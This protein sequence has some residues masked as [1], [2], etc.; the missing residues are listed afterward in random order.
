MLTK[1]WLFI[2]CMLLLAYSAKAQTMV[3]EFSAN[4]T[5]GCAPLTVNFRDLTTGNPKYWNWDFGNGTLA[6]VQFPTVVYSQPGTY[7][8]TLVVRNADGTNGITKTH[9]ITVHPSPTAD[10]FANITMGCTPVNIQFVDN[11]SS[12]SGNIVSWAWDFGDGTT[13]NEQN[14]Q[15]TYT[16]T[17]FYSVTLTV[18]SSTGCKSITT[19]GR[20]IRIVA[21]VKP[22]FDNSKITACEAPYNIKFNN[23]TSSPG[24]VTYQWNLDNGTN[25]TETSPTTTYATPGTYNVTLTATSD[26]GCTGTITKAVTLSG[27]TTSIK[28]P[29]EVC[30]NQT[31]FFV[32]ESSV[33]PKSTVWDFGNG[34]TK[35]GTDDSTVYTTPATYTVK[36][37]NT[38]E[39][40]T[41]SATKTITVRPSPSIDF[42]ATNAAACKP[43]LPVTFQD[44]SPAPIVKWFWEFGDGSTGT[45]QTTTHTYNAEG[46]YDV[47]VTFTDD[48]G[49]EGKITKQAV[50][51]ITKPTITITNAGAGGC[52]PYT[53]TPTI[54]VNAV[55]GVATYVW[56]WADG[57]T[58]TTSGSD[59]IPSHIYTNT[60]TYPVKVTITTNSGCT[61][62]AVM[63]DPV[64]TGTKPAP[65]FSISATDVCASATITFNDLTPPPVDEW[66]WN[67]GDGTTS[68]DRNPT[69]QFL[70]TGNFIV[71]LTAFNNRCA[72]TSTGQTVHI[73]GPI[74]RFIYTVDCNNPTSVT[75]TDQSV[76][77]PAHAA[78]TTYFWEFGD[79]ANST[80][81][82]KD[83]VFTYPALGTYTVKL[84]VTGGG[85]S[86][87]LAKTIKL[88]KEKADFTVA[89]TPACRNANI[90]VTSKNDPEAISKYEW[91]TDGGAYNPGG[92]IYNTSFATL[93]V[94]GIKLRITDINGCT[95][96]K[97]SVTAVTVTGPTPNFTAASPGGCKD[98]TITFN[99]LS[100]PAGDIQKWT[101]DFGDGKTQSFTNAPFT[102]TYTDTGEYVPLLTVQDNRGCID[103]FR[104]KD[105]IFI[106]TPKADFNSDLTVVC[107]TSNVHF[108]DQSTG[109]GL[110]YLWD[111][112]NGATST[113]Q[114][115]VYSY[116]GGETA[117]NVKL[118]VTDRGGCSDAITRD[119]YITTVKPKPDFD[120]QD[121]VTIC[122]PLETKFTFK[123]K[124]YE[125][126]E[127]DFGDGSTSTL[128]NPSHFY[129]AYG[130]FTATLN[131]TGYGGCIESV[132]KTVHVYD[133]N[134]VTSFNYNPK[135]A[136]NELLVD[137]SITTPPDLKYVFM[138]GDGSLDTNMR[139]T[140]QHFYKSPA[141]YGPAV[142][143]TDNQGC[144]ADVGGTIKVIGAEPFF[145]V[146]RK[147]FCDEGVVYFTNYTIGNDPVVTRTWNF[148]DGSATTDDVNP[149]HN[150]QQPGTYLV[151][152]NVITQAGCTKTITDTIRVYRTPDPSIAGDS[153]GCLN[154][155]LNLR[156]VLAVPDTA[157][158]WKWS[159]GNNTSLS[160]QNISLNFPNPGNYTVYLQA[161]NLLGCSDTTS[162]A[163]FVPPIPDITI[164][165]DPVIPVS[166]GVTLPVTYGEDIATYKWTPAKN[167]SCTDC[168]T[169]YANPKFTT[170][171]NIKVADIYGCTN[172]K[173][174]TVTVV[175]NG[176][177][178]FIPNTFSPN[179]D[180]V[181]DVFA[182][183][184]VGLTRVNSMRIFN[185]WGEMVFEKMN[186]MANDRTPTGGW[187]GTYKGKPASADV[188]VYIIEFV[189][190]NAAI[191]PVK[192]NVALMR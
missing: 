46:V 183:R 50:V 54:D 55:D 90:T 125:S 49:C 166:T 127:W 169:P 132:S 14:P 42:T 2:P 70:D 131:L 40:C 141:F 69:H 150:Y 20:Y 149:V 37:V 82:V 88:V 151:S 83:P 103:T 104:L 156:G 67:F 160:T 155:A 186:F 159:F 89:P 32:N 122:P 111:F 115:P 59:P 120:I 146:D 178:Y 65:N 68:G 148:G 175:C 66:H 138:F 80:A 16:N 110:T 157:T 134:T 174:V 98:A 6:N 164:A 123:G 10:F 187:D 124:D 93:G 15:K 185:R 62:T 189:C 96:I 45:G 35:T 128:L 167:L 31:V 113:D 176:L 136:C 153:I 25:S 9:Y 29:D 107:P 11:S 95:D 91:A 74:A 97:D 76:V 52:I 87:T 171:Y 28:V 114:N 170:T 162:K 73:K 79:A 27:P 192:G 179:G 64:K 34:V 147:K 191:V 18:T 119:S 63:S 22:E 165:G 41:G 137:F 5:S 60:G 99:D 154:D 30:Q 51:K 85:C 163:L 26:F 38:Y 118:V 108:T 78:T 177:N 72:A 48:K 43:P 86:F 135:E 101:F 12:P 7:T 109:K 139:T 180:G 4:V 182:P 58:T 61:E 145:A 81:N 44:A 152:Q 39:N 84:T 13:S 112:G 17:G 47:K 57:T 24:N 23:L 188:Y 56:D 168:P 161:S 100:T 92:A 144:V 19:K 21:G 184:G 116:G 172:N 105:T 130:Y 33:A 8:V 77:D 71:K 106:S 142:H 3:P 126:F 75:F 117:Y 190:E 133:V 94:H 158:I 36:L 102:H 140:Y 181:N 121:T 143:Y 53:F 173:D 129:N 1:Q